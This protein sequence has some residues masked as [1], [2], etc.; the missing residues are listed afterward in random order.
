MVAAFTGAENS[1][2]VKPILAVAVTRILDAF[3]TI[4]LKVLINE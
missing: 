4:F 1:P 3:F 2:K